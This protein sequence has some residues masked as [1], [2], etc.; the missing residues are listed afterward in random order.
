MKKEQTFKGV[1][2]GRLLTN[3]CMCKLG[4]GQKAK[5]NNGITRQTGAD[6]NSKTYP[7]THARDCK[8]VNE[9]T[10]NHKVPEQTQL[11]TH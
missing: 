10:R 7:N 4:T 1:G 6:S 8:E 9:N 11:K 5:G 2:G 3:I